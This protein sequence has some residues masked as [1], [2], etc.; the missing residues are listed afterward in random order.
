MA[1]IIK[2]LSTAI[3]VCQAALSEAVEERI[4]AGFGEMV[5][6]TPADINARYWLM[7]AL[8]PLSRKELKAIVDGFLVQM[9][10][11]DQCKKLVKFLLVRYPAYYKEDLLTTE[12][13]PATDPQ[14]IQE[15]LV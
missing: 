1:D 3:E 7:Q 14:E 4:V 2:Q 12:E 11:D 8:S 13:E 10:D 5:E 9:M 15:M 6:S